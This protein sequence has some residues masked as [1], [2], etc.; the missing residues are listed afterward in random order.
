[1]NDNIPESFP[2]LSGCKDNPYGALGF[3]L[4]FPVVQRNETERED[5]YA[6]PLRRYDL[7]VTIGEIFQRPVHDDR[8]A[9]DARHIECD[10]DSAHGMSGAPAFNERGEVIGIFVKPIAFKVGSVLTPTYQIDNCFRK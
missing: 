5:F 3:L 10:A 4:G 9:A 1:M 8:L 7:S 6:Y 2:R